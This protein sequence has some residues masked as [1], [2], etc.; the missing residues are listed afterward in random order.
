MKEK[1]STKAKSEQLA[2]VTI[3]AISLVCDASLALGAV[4]ALRLHASNKHIP[5]IGAL[6]ISI[7][8]NKPCLTKLIA[9]GVLKF[10]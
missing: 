3:V 10:I 4:G 1:R 6:R 7:Y 5:L 2:Q 9:I 8:I